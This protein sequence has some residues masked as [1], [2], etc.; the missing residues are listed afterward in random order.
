MSILIVITCLIYLSHVYVYLCS[1]HHFL[2]MF[3]KSDLSIY[4]YLL[5]FGFTIVPLIF[6]MLLVT[7]CTY[8]PESHHLIMYTCDCLSTPT[9]FILRTCW[10]AF[11]TTLDLHVQILE[12]NLWWPSV[13][14]QR[15]QRKRG[16]AVVY[17]EPHFLPAPLI[18]S[19]DLILLLMGIFQSFLCLVIIIYVF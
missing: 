7:A 18:P 16:L 12:S 5:D 15:A 11:L 19:R 1:R 10:V 4:M 17:P 2:F 9:G 8:M 13:V 14:D 3:Y 6:F